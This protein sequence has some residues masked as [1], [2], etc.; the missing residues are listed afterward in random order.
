MDEN[1]AFDPN[2]S[3]CESGAS[4]AWNVV[5]FLEHTEPGVAAFGARAAGNAPGVL[6]GIKLQNSFPAE[7]GHS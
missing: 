6:E 2:S 1:H 3:R 7:A 4:E 5:N